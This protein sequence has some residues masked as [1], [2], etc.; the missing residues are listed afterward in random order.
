MFYKVKLYILNKMP[1]GK[2]SLFLTEAAIR[3]IIPN[4]T[5]KFK[6]ISIRALNPLFCCR[7]F[8]LGI[9]DLQIIDYC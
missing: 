6:L 1:L 2:F 9:L 4:L 7:I 3:N 8:S 5:I